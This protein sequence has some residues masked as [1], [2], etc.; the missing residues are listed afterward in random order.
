MRDEFV[1][2][3][4]DE[5][6][7]EWRDESNWRGGLLGFYVAPRDPRLIVPKRWLR[8]GWTFNLAH[9]ASWLLL[10]ALIVIPLIAIALVNLTT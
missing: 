5:L 9:R 3:G 2:N 6:E 4:R 1:T 10:A 8:L 7:R